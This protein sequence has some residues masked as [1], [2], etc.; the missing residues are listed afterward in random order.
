MPSQVTQKSK[1]S[2]TNHTALCNLDVGYCP[3]SSLLASFPCYAQSY[4]FFPEAK[5]SPASGLLH[6]L[7]PSPGGSALF[8]PMAA[9]PTSG[10]RLNVFPGH[11]LH[12]GPSLLHR[13]QAWSVWGFPSQH[14]LTP[15]GRE[16]TS[17]VHPS[18]SSVRGG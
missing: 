11:H 7:C 5:V 15:K 16:A 6:M 13:G 14:L 1:Y 3:P 18:S 10:H 9:T 12:S 8:L 17:R 4:L 2:T